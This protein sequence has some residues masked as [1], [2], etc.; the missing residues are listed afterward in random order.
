EENRDDMELELVEDAG[1]EREL[2]GSG[3]VD[4]HVP[5][6]RSLLGPGHRGRHVV[7]VRNQWPLR[8]ADAGLRTGEDEDRYAVVVVAAPTA[9]RL[10]RPPPGDDRA[11][12]HHLVHHLAVHTR[13]AAWDSSLVGLLAAPTTL[14]PA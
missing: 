14:G 12:G 9:R 11:R 5:V 3:T 10:E 13:P 7:H 6:A 1:G 8:S 2:R 4:E